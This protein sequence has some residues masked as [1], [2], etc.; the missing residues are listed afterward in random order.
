M[1]SLLFCI[2]DIKLS[3]HIGK[4]SYTDTINW[5][6]LSTVD[7]KWSHF[8]EWSTCS[9]S[10]GDGQQTRNRI[11]L[12]AA[13]HGGKDCIGSDEETRACKTQECPGIVQKI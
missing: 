3:P 8:G 5:F 11:I 7:C 10:C 4:L 2:E 9:V 1:K 12:N 6:Y 13:K